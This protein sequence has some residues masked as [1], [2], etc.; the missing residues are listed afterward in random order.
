MSDRTAWLWLL[1]AL[2]LA[3]WGAEPPPAPAAQFK[4]DFIYLR[5]YGTDDIGY[6]TL[7]D[8]P[9]Q[10]GVVLVPDGHGVDAWMKTA[11]DFVAQK[12]YI[13]LVLDLYNGNVTADRRQVAH[14]EN[15]LEEKR[16]LAALQTAT[17]FFQQSPR[18]KTEQVLLLG[19][20]PQE[21]CLLAFAAQKHHAISGLAVINSLQAPAAEIL[22]RARYPVLFQLNHNSPA[23]AD[24]E[25]R[26]QDTGGQELLEVGTVARLVPGQRRLDEAQ[27][28]QIEA[29]MRKNFNAERRKSLLQRLRDIF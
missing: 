18:F 7:P 25:R 10:A 14:L 17:V 29:F 2:P 20:G 1:L 8:S 3:A 9:P 21:R 22:K 23:A 19:F 6:L 24:L 12:G 11:A 28:R 27:W 13:V 16:A 26:I 5:D 15:E 4:G